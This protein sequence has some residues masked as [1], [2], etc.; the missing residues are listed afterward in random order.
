MIE[1]MYLVETHYNDRLVI[2][3]TA[4]RAVADAWA[5]AYGTDR[6]RVFALTEL[7]TET[8]IA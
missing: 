4:A 7:D 3:A 6:V 8:F 2:E 1:Q 5:R